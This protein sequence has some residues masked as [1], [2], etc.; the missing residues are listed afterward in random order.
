MTNNEAISKLSADMLKDL[1]EKFN[2]FDIDESGH[3]TTSELHACMK[4]CGE[5]IPGFKL[6]QYI[7]EVDKNR[8][9]TVEFDE[10]VEIYSK[11]STQLQASGFKSM[12]RKFK[13]SVKIQGGVSQSSADGTTHSLTDSERMAFCDWINS[14]LEDDKD[15][16]RLGLL[17]VDPTSE[18]DLFQKIQ[19]GII[20]CK[21]INLSAP[22][23]VDERA[24][25]IKPNDKLNIYLKQENQ[26]LALNSASA[27]GCYIVNI[28]PQD[29]MNGTPHLV[30]GL[31][32][33]IIRIGLLAKINLAN[34]PGLA[35]LL[36]E[37]ETMDDLMKLSP[38]EILL[39]WVNYHLEK[40]GSNKRIKNFGKDIM[41]SEAYT[42]LL[43]QI[44]PPQL[45]IDE[46]PLREKDDLKRAELVLVNADKMK[47][48]KFVQPSD[49]VKGHSKLNMAFVANLFNTYPCLPP[50]D[51]IE[52]D[53]EEY[54]ETREELTFRNWMNSLGANPFVNHLY[55]NLHDGLVLFQL[56]DKIKPGVVN[57]D[58]VNKPPFK[59]MGG[60]MKKIENCNYAV[61]LGHE[62]KFSLIGIGGEDIHNK[63]KTLVLALVWQ[64]MRAY[65]LK[66]LQNLAKS[67]KPLEDKEIIAWVNDKLESAGKTS[68]I[69]SF[70]DPSISTSLPVIDLVDAIKP[71]S[72]NY[73]VVNA[74]N[75]EEE[76]VDNAKYALSMARKIGARV[77]AL[78]EDLVEV[79]QKMVLTV[80]A[81]LM[82]AVYSKN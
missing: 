14:T 64:M 61:E 2:E 22:D 7:E 72:I 74:G 5:D 53:F 54:E 24:I 21:L 75:T 60:K 19:N 13:N 79:N 59:Q 81:C 67:D 77:Y 28:G 20:L 44:A 37:G 57:W 36:H 11:E 43:S 56:F 38:E 40:S 76:K 50:L 69:K 10:F 1:R 66:I 25:N 71:G 23:T 45:G 49:I 34:V 51:D 68:I 39:R 16:S 35:R 42:I 17:P 52:E 55:N 4:A 31:I 30:L 26:I 12:V 15:L 62:L 73:D 8:N 63:T 32:W 47:C 80:F 46:S 70:K 9:G 18:S 33:Q 41:D 82:S 48:R 65:T 27:I 6:R 29:L 78:P 58:K 3:I